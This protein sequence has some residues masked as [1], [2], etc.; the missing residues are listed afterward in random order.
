MKVFK[1]ELDWVVARSENVL[2]CR[3]VLRKGRF[4]VKKISVQRGRFLV[5]WNL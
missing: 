2:L 3:V 4:R 1:G 5:A